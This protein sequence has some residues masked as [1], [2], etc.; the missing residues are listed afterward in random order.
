MTYLGDESSVAAA[1]PV[2]LY[3]FEGTYVSYFYTSGPAIVTYGGHD[4]IPIAIE[5]TEVKVGTQEDDG[6]DISIK[7]P[8]TELVIQHYAFEISP[9]RLKLTIFRQEPSET[10]VY[11]IGPVNNVSV[12]ED[13]RGVVRCPSVLGAALVGN[14]PNVYYQ[15]PCN[16]TLY[17]GRCGISFALFSN[18]TAV[19]SISDDGRTIGVGS[20]GAL[21]GELIGGELALA[22]GERRMIVSQTGTSIV[23]NFPFSTIAVALA[24]T[25]AAG[26][27]YAYAGDCKSKFNNQPR[28]GGFV[29]IPP[30][31]PFVDGIEP[32]AEGVADDACVFTP[33]VPL[34]YF[35][36]LEIRTNLGPNFPVIK[37]WS[38]SASLTIGGVEQVAVL[39][40]E[41]YTD[42]DG[43]GPDPWTL[44]YSYLL[45]WKTYYF[46]PTAAA[47]RGEA[48]FATDPFVDGL[49]DTLNFNIQWPYNDYIFPGGSVFG[50]GLGSMSLV[51]VSA[52]GERVDFGTVAIFGLWPASYSLA[53]L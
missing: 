9:P 15:T 21:D 28:F 48:G 2:E 33:P 47:A 22:N 39:N 32:A 36:Y 19:A 40:S 25:V 10:V 1:Q 23:V 16:H 42:Y 26:C 35:G 6:L 49:P 20:I 51:F 31:N 3:K 4:Y 53:A 30:I 12:D 43:G 11:W 45:G 17:D 5:R 34:D 8:V 50:D 13:G 38:W 24:C 52:S 37:P 18:A 44:P 7:L 29:F 46:D 41:N 14:I 27:D